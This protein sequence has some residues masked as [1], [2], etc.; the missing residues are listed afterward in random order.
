[1]SEMSEWQ[2]I[3]HSACGPD[4]LRYHAD[5]DAV[6]SL[7]FSLAGLHDTMAMHTDLKSKCW[8]RMLSASLPQL[9]VLRQEL[10][11]VADVY[12]MQLPPFPMAADAQ[13]L[14]SVNAGAFRLHCE[15]SARV[16][17]ELKSVLAGMRDKLDNWHGY[18][19]GKI[20]LIEDH[21]EGQRD[22]S[23]SWIY[24][25]SMVCQNYTRTYTALMS[26]APE[27]G[28]PPAAPSQPESSERAMQTDVHAL[29][30]RMNELYS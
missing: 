25:E 6:D 9:A 1:M 30:D 2:N 14:I 10:P 19:F 27:A 23:A 11:P 7:L 21:P 20:T 5:V 28:Q 12:R 18:E 26:E 22:H 13:L 24:I 17:A 3:R 15:V 16:M 8:V 29:L 4:I